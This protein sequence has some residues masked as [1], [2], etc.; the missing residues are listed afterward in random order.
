MGIRSKT[1]T[2]ASAMAGLAVFSQAPEFAQQYRQRIG[3][4]VDELKMV[5]VE[6]D[7]DA[8]GSQMSRQEALNELTGSLET[9][10]RNRGESMTKTISRHERLSEQR[11]WLEKSHPLTRPLLV[12]KSPDSKLLN[13][14]WEIYEPALPL[15]APGALYGGL[16][17]LLAI[18][19]ARFGIGGVRRIGKA[20][21]DRRL[22]SGIEDPPLIDETQVLAISDE[23]TLDEDEPYSI[24]T[25]ANNETLA[26]RM[27]NAVVPRKGQRESRGI[28]EAMQVAPVK[29]TN[30]PY[31]KVDVVDPDN[32]PTPERKNSE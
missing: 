12:L 28:P 4:A 25:S 30:V 29:R 13:R 2:I 22:A 5:V 20:R 3:G 14:A 11:E 7:K 17:A 15:T 10:P 8:S 19:L 1:V 18:I 27:E 21:S 26:R 32:K 24:D 6:F 23:T 16:G 31:L 9:F